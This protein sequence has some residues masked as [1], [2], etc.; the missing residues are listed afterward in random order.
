METV[1]LNILCFFVFP[2]GT[3]PNSN[4]EEVK[5]A[6]NTQAQQNGWDM[7]AE[8]SSACVLV[9]HTIVDGS[10]HVEKNLFSDKNWDVAVQNDPEEP[11]HDPTGTVPIIILIFFLW[12]MHYNDLRSKLIGE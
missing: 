3:E 6:G 4:W 10:Q 9:N 2:L 11:M 7:N 5:S 1:T 12:N 8:K